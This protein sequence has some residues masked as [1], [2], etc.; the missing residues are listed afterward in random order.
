MVGALLVLS[1]IAVI[2][3]MAGAAA[4]SRSLMVDLLWATRPARTGGLSAMAGQPTRNTTLI[5]L[6]IG[7][8]GAGIGASY[9]LSPEAGILAL[10]AGGLALAMLR[11][12]AIRKIGGQT[13]DVCGAGQMMAETAMLA[14]Y[15]AAV[16][17]RTAAALFDRIEAEAQ[18]RGFEVRMLY[19]L[20]KSPELQI[21][22]V[23]IRV[24]DGGHDV[25]EDKIRSRRSRSLAQLAWF[26]GRV[27]QLLIFDNSTAEPALIAS[28]SPDKAL[29]WHQRPAKALHAELVA[30]GLPVPALPLA[31]TSSARSRV[32]TG[33]CASNST[34]S[35]WRPIVAPC[36]SSA[37]AIRSISPRTL[38][39][40]TPSM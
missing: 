32:I 36:R 20:L 25:P 34:I 3:L 6:A 23:R 38:S 33:F 16:A 21:E 24:A 30:A 26:A 18:A 9:M 40:F 35:A 29:R 14:V 22:R 10:V 4:F 37:A 7:G 39:R 31:N 17:F 1:P 8:L 11:S 27:D 5:A 12:L 13:G 19:V 15:A 28:K 2:V